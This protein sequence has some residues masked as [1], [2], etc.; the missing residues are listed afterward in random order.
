MRT[1]FI[2][3]FL[4][5]LGCLYAQNINQDSLSALAV[6]DSLPP[7]KP[8]IG[9][10][11]K[12]NGK[13]IILRW[14]PNHHI[15]WQF[16]NQNGY[17][18]E[19]ALLARD[20]TFNTNPVFQR[21]T[22]TTIKPLP[23]EQWQTVVEQD[24]IFGAIAAQ[25]I[26]GKDFV[27]QIGDLQSIS[28]RYTE[29]TNR[30]AI[31]LFSADLSLTVATASGLR[32]IDT[33]IKNNE[34]YVYRIV[35]NVPIDSF[36]IDIGYCVVKAGEIV[37]E[38]NIPL[39]KV[40]SGDHFLIL[41]WDIVP[42]FTAY[43]LER[44]E[45]G[46]KFT[47]VSQIPLIGIKPDF[48][49]SPETR[50]SFIDSVRVNYKTLYYRLKGLNAFG[51][52]S[53]YST[54]VSGYG[55][56]L[57]PPA[58]LSL[59]E[60][61]LL[62]NATFQLRWE[63]SIVEPDLAGY[64][65]EWAPSYDGP[66][67]RKH[68]EI[69]SPKTSTYIVEGDFYA[70]NFF[71]VIAIDTAGNIRYS[72][73]TQGVVID[74]IPPQ[75][76][77]GIIGAIDSIGI[78]KIQWSIGA[79]PDIIGYRV[80]FANNPQHR[81]TNLT[82]YPLQDTLFRDTIS[83][84]ALSKKLYYKIVAVDRNF[85][86]SPYSEI[87]TIIRPDTIPPIAPVFSDVLVTDS[88]VQLKWI[89]SSSDDVAAQWLHRKDTNNNWQRT[90]V[91]PKNVQEYLVKGITPGKFYDYAVEAIDSSG[92][93]SGWTTPVTVRVYT[94][95]E[96][97]AIEDFHAKFDQENKSILLEWDANTLKPKHFL[98]YRAYNAFALSS[99]KS[100]EANR[101]TYLDKALLGKGIYKYAIRAINPDGS[102]TAISKTVELVV[103]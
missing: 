29:E 15:A 8:G 71:Q 87:L 100:V 92:N 13:E 91:L 41:N 19:R 7:A 97:A 56:D 48:S 67:E 33:N 62:K 101:N 28:N 46:K 68:E 50:Q 1:I 72:N 57:T 3:Y 84:N 21:L 53:A 81:F 32:F 63:K 23:L 65:V 35:P 96:T 86:H 66:F 69:L 94:K 70:N 38:G 83:L 95:S 47:P 45:D 36:R 60:A 98:I 102:Q 82:G 74:T 58:P 14:A 89:T 12:S 51:E 90:T 37:P 76:P 2:A 99:Y 85:N 4:L 55:K 93:R 9:V 20:S 59:T 43:I 39:P 75:A 22:Q 52:Q 18:V 42:D 49:K 78:V 44:S 16:L 64:F 31:A 24:S 103:E 11:G 40:V 25:A 26:H 5:N 79:E 54:I 30:W 34:V 80:F 17:F 10:I 6:P 61:K 27:T 73:K 88:T 77:T